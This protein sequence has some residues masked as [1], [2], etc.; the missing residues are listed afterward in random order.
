[1]QSA[2]IGLHKAIKTFN[3]EKAGFAHHLQYYVRS[4]CNDVIGLRGKRDPS[5][6]VFSLNK[7]INGEGGDS[8]EGI[9]LLSDPDAEMAFIDV[10]DQIYITQLRNALNDCLSQMPG[11]LADIL[12]SNHLEGETYAEIATR[13]GISKQRVEKYAQKA[14]K[15]IRNSKLIK[16]LEQKTDEIYVEKIRH[17]NVHNIRYMKSY[18]KH[19]GEG[20]MGLNKVI[21]SAGKNT[22]ARI[23]G[24]NREWQSTGSA[25][26]AK[27]ITGGLAEVALDTAVE[28]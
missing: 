1:V 12:R 27:R 4:T 26:V 24:C 5:H 17:K 14:L 15:L 2:F 23:M 22:E 19:C 21:A 10:A 7:K 16:Q 18:L 13:Y 20:N 11:K 28:A 8:I 9:E 6:D 3:P 25:G